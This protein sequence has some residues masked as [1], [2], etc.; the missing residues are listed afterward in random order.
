MLLDEIV[1]QKRQE[2]IEL[3]KRLDVQK[4]KSLMAGLPRTRNFSKALP[5]GK[6]SLIAEMKKASPS[7]GI[8]MAKY[9]P[10]YLA[11][12][13]EENGAAALS[14][15]TDVK[16][17]QG[18]LHHIKEA[19]ESTTIPIMRKDFIVDE[20][21]IYESRIAGADAILLIVRI[22]T[23]EQLKQYLAT[24]QELGLECLV[25]VHNEAEVEQALK[26]EAKIIGIN[27]RD[28]DSLKVNF[29][30]TLKILDKFPELKEK[31]VVSESGISSAAQ[32]KALK[33]RGVAAML[34][35]ESL[36]ISPNLRE[37]IKELLG[38]S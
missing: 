21:Q 6:L 18:Q 8:I 19:K 13:Y 27:N 9:E 2:V 36:L 38:N 37:K 10:V 34:V 20:A 3:K 1:A 29:N 24:A 32:T 28:L 11:K 4:I 35:G 26:V 22:L 5:W 25:E 33:N 31:I 12:T 15:L 14:V 23:E 17:F 7:A 16:F 30:T